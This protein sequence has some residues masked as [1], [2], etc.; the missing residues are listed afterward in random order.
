MHILGFE[1]WW[2]SP[3]AAAAY[4]EKSPG[5]NLKLTYALKVLSEVVICK[6]TKTF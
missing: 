4:A 5:A 6:E 2:A 1:W 3:N